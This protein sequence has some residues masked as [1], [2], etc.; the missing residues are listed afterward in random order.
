MVQFHLG[1]FL[2]NTI[3]KLCVSVSKPQRFRRDDVMNHICLKYIINSYP[4]DNVNIQRLFEVTT[5]GFQRGCQH[6]S[7]KFVRSHVTTQIAIYSVDALF[8]SPY[9]E[10]AERKRCGETNTKIQYSLRIQV[11]KI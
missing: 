11:S 1:V 6:T 5:F 4:F 10:A 3:F 8:I 7:L 9:Q 2:I